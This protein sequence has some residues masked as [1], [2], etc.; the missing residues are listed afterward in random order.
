MVTRLPGGWTALFMILAVRPIGAQDAG[1]RLWPGTVEFAATSWDAA[2]AWPVAP[3]WRSGALPVAWGLRAGVGPLAV[4]PREEFIRWYD[5]ELFRLHITPAAFWALSGLTFS[6][7]ETIQDV[8]NRFIPS[9]ESRL[10]DYIQYVPALGVYGLNLAGL[11]GRHTVRRASLTGGLA[12]LL[13][14]G[15]VTGL[16]YTTGVVR[17]D[18][19]ATTSW[20]SGHTATAFLAATFYH[21][22]YGQYSPLHSVAAYSLASVTGIFRQLNN[23]HWLTDVFAGAGFGIWSANI[24]Y[25]LMD[26]WMGDDGLNPPPQRTA[27]DSPP[28]DPSFIN[29]RVGYA[30]AGGDL[31]PN[32]ESI[33]A[34]EG[35]SFAVA[36]AWFPWRSVG[37]GVDLSFGVF[38]VNSANLELADPDLI[39]ISNG[40][41]TEALGNNTIYVGP[42]FD[43]EVSESVSLLGKAT[44]GYWGGATGSVGIEVKEAAR[45]EFGDYL[46]LVTYDPSDTFGYA[47]GAG[48]RMD[49]SRSLA[50]DLYVDY[51]WATPDV[52]LT[53]VDD[54][55]PDTGEITAG[56]QETNAVNWNYVSIGVAVTGLVR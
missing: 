11:P 6:Q 26:T 16:K 2:D 48:V 33:F 27:F 42:F 3:G 45:D 1:G 40:L 47:L 20:P 18:G 15:T 50:F 30:R 49:V 29:L 5:G 7:R 56:Q 10:D 13:T 19:S 14:A 43:V 46:P 31:A 54:V 22:E 51:N 8:R 24:A 36:A 17:P 41:E 4:H 38:P 53:R 12:A 44:A 52:T 9:F 25:Y 37:F 23:R 34:E 35:A 32:T 28:G 55:D 21:K 39:E